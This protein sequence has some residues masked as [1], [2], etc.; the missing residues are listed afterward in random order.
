MLMNLKD[1][2]QIAE[3]QE[4]AVGAFNA[5]NLDVLESILRAEELGLPAIA[6]FAQRHEELPRWR[7]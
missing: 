5:A 2:L 1:I 3:E 6:Q 4:I 7:Q